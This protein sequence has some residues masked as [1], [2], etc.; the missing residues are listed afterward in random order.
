MTRRLMSTVGAFALGLSLNAALMSAPALAQEVEVPSGVAMTLYD[1]RL[2]EAPLLARFRFVSPTI[3]PEGEGRT[4][5][6][7]VDDLQFLCEA[8]VMPSL[9][10][11]AWTGTDVVLSVSSRE[12]EFGIFDDSV[13]QFFQPYR[14]ADGTCLWEE[15]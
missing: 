14:I 8:V 13:T 2:E 4:F 11:N 9:A 5:G 3:D 12:T 1:V 10:A 7:L 6:D 15:F